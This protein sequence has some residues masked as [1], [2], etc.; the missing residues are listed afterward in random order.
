MDRRTLLTGIALLAIIALAG[1]FRFYDIT[2]YPGGLFPDEAANGED[3][4]LILSG[5]V[6]PFYPRGNGREALFFYLQAISVALFGIGVWQLHIVAA[7]VGTTTVAALYF[8]VRPY[9]GRLAGLLAALLLATNQWHVTM[10]RT[11]FRAIMIPLFVAL[12]TAWVG[13]CI[14]AV[15]R[16]RAEKSATL[17]QRQLWWSYL[18]AALAGA[19]FAGGFY[20]YI[21]YRVMI[22]VVIGVVFFLLLAAMHPKIGFPHAKRY[23]RQAVTA[24]IAGSIVLLPLVLYFVHHPDAFVGR[25]GQVSIFNQELQQQYGGGTVW[26]TLLYSLRE[27]LYS[28]FAGH[29]DL[30][31]RHNVA[32][33]PLLNPLVGILFLLGLSWAINGLV[34][35]LYTIVRGRELHLGMIHPYLL[36]LLSGFLVPIITTAE[37]MPHGLRSVG[38]VAPIF[39]LAGTAAAVCW[40]WLH[41]RLQPAWL[42]SVGVGV[43][44][45]VLILFGVY[46][47]TLYFVFARTSAD[48]AYAYRSDLT[49]VANYVRTYHQEHP[50]A[51]RQYLVLDSFSLQT[52]H[53]LTSVAAHEYVTGGQ[54][55]P[56][57]DQHIWR[58][59]D[60]ATSYRTPLL[61]DETIVFTQSTI[62]DADRYAQ[63]Y[64]GQLEL[65][66]SER[67]RYNQEIIRVYQLPTTA[68]AEGEGAG[69]DA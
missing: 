68:P 3:I 51:P 49:I 43:V 57:V 64:S 32:G 44:A 28:F 8:A 5:D 56:D 58:Q 21:A 9:F 30:N 46:D 65:I 66:Y 12:F 13:Y 33:W 35:V 50:A 7:A 41:K 55:H 17:Q 63:E 20:T 62:V 40:R 59:L 47:A 60:P 16:A 1:L 69:L 36:L 61:A 4:M 67:N 14:A 48:A 39:I 15:K 52:V 24:V 18:Y 19:A 42:H 38:L 2:N 54:A 22:G 45:G 6:R 27:T 37:G 31:W 34:V 10:S 53:W 26:G 11:G 25:A 23:W 29:G